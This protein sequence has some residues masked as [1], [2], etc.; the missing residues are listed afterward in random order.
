MV[1][2]EVHQDFGAGR[3]ACWTGAWH[4]GGDDLL[5]ELWVGE[6]EHGGL[7]HEWVAEQHL[8]DLAGVDVVAAGDDQLAGAAGDG[9]IAIGAAPTQVAG[10]EPAFGVERFGR[11]LGLL[12]IAFEDVWTAHLDLAR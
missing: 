10:V 8:F 3:L 4:D 7:G 1:T 9:E 12:P 5:A 11:G 6:A 2:A